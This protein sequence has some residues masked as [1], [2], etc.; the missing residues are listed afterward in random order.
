MGHPSG[1]LLLSWCGRGPG[2]SS[3][4]LAWRRGGFQ[5]ASGLEVQGI[6]RGS[7]IRG[8][9]GQVV[10]APTLNSTTYVL[11]MFSKSFVPLIQLQS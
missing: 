5:V 6:R 10:H 9:V 3:T 4:Y 7:P 1:L 8:S 2:W 11:R